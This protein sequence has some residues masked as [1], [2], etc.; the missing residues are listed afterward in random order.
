MKEKAHDTAMFKTQYFDLNW[1]KLWFWQKDQEVI[2]CFNYLC[3][4]EGRWLFVL[5][6]FA[7]TRSGLCV[8][9]I[10]P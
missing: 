7:I 3:I 5:R 6:V 10:G 4:W 8:L 1:P 9:G 2:F